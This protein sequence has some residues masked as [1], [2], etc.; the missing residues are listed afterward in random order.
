VFD[1]TEPDNVFLVTRA[2]TRDPAGDPEAFTAGDLGPEGIHFVPFHLSPIKRALL[3]VA[4]EVSGT[5]RV[6]SIKPGPAG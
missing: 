3:L 6:Y 4:N 2:S 1:V 5:V